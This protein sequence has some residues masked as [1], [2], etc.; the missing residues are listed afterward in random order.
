MFPKNGPLID[1]N[2]SADLLKPPIKEIVDPLAGQSAALPDRLQLIPVHTLP[3][4]QE[5]MLRA[6]DIKVC[7]MNRIYNLQQINTSTYKKVYAD[8]AFLFDWTE[9]KF[10][11]R[12]SPEQRSELEYISNPFDNYYVMKYQGKDWFSNDVKIIKP[13]EFNFLW[14]V[15]YVLYGTEKQLK[16]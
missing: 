10:N 9:Q 15:L 13:M 2:L 16:M 14:S 5:Y 4:N 7:P 11:Y 3:K 1:S 8:L 12:F 6:Y